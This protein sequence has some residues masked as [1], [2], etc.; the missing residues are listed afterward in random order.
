MRTLDPEKVM[1]NF[2]DAD[3][4]LRQIPVKQAKLQVVLAH[5]AAQF[6]P[7][8]RYPERQVNETLKRFHEDFCTLRRNL[9]DYRY[10]GRADGDY[11]RLPTDN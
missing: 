9:V 7:G 10:L 6:E 4:R 8:V 5:L 2:I 11:W 3:G 1:R